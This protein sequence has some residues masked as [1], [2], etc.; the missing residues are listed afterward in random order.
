M[1]Q[2]SPDRAR[3]LQLTLGAD[4][5][6]GPLQVR[7]SDC[8]VVATIAGGG[9]SADGR[10]VM[11]LRATWSPNGRFVAFTRWTNRV[12][13]HVADAATGAE[14]F[15]PPPSWWTSDPWWSP[16]GELLA[17]SA[18]NSTKESFPPPPMDAAVLS[19]DGIVTLLT[20]DAASASATYTP[21]GWL[22]P[23]RPLFTRSTSSG[24]SVIEL[25]TDGRAP[26]T[27]STKPGTVSVAPDRAS[28]FIGGGDGL[29]RIGSD[30]SE[31]RVLSTPSGSVSWSPTTD[32][33]STAPNDRLGELIVFRPDG[34]VVLKVPATAMSDNWG[35]RA[36]TS[37]SPDGTLV[38]WVELG[39]NGDGRVLVLHPDG[40]LVEAGPHK[41][42]MPGNPVSW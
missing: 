21:A 15:A 37:W 11:D 8:S 36:S 32:L 18:S 4:G 1:A 17:V 6:T 2:W 16:T 10:P 33:A 34:T 40:T 3:F 7:R 20:T 13:V 27:W 19:P 39:T 12:A 24:R 23:T 41:P 42:S 31:G 5:S 30:G 22:A 28:I 38:A 35:Q 9:R 14:A 26:R 25:P 29:W